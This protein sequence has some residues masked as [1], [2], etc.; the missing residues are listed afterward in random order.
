MKDI[1]DDYTHI[2]EDQ[3]DAPEHFIR[4]SGYHLVSNLLGRFYVITQ[5]RWS[6]ELRPNLWFL[7][8][9]IPSRYRRSTIQRK[10]NKIYRNCVK[11]Y[12]MEVNYSNSEEA[13]DKAEEDAW[14]SVIESG[15]D[16]GI[17][18]KICD[19]DLDNFAI[20]S[21][22]FGG[23]LNKMKNKTYASNLDTLF[24]KLYYGQGGKLDYIH[25]DRYLPNNQYVTMFAGMQE[26]ER[27]MNEN[28]VRQGLLRRILLSYIE[29]KEEHQKNWK[30]PF[31][32]FE[33][34]EREKTPELDKLG[35]KITEKMIETNK[36]TRT[37]TAVR[38]KKKHFDFPTPMIEIQMRPR[39]IKKL[40]KFS[41]KLEFQVLKEANNTNIYKQTLW[42]IMAKMTV[43]KGISRVGFH[44]SDNLVIN[45]KD[46]KNS[47][48]L[49]DKLTGEIDEILPRLGMSRQN[50][51][52]QEKAHQRIM[53]IVKKEGGHVSSST[54]LQSIKGNKSEL[55]APLE[56]LIARDDLIFVKFVGVKGRGGKKMRFALNKDYADR[57]VNQVAKKYGEAKY[58]NDIEEI[59]SYDGVVVYTVTSE[60]ST[61]LRD[62][63]G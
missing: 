27:Y 50:M 3:T 52:S 38:K 15:S 14:T 48:K 63:W 41:E 53:D 2:V 11:D 8:S 32:P 62:I 39:V 60:N 12:L 21:H 29:P 47:K 25:S 9:S 35:E 20:L 33:E 16:E 58:R 19:S 61:Q 36:F 30:E 4:A 28:V 18:Q 23:V 49:F 6:N 24:S 37:N 40:N 22:E 59:G 44:R 10:H 17:T 34:V 42:E 5:G 7:I 51:T 54:L 46:Y 45:Q 43:V 55:V 57:L 13:G 26:P 1:I 31:I 56:T